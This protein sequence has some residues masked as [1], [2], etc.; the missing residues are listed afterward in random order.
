MRKMRRMYAFV[1]AL[2]LMLALGACE[3][4]TE[5]PE[6][7]A[8]VGDLQDD[9]TALQEDF[10]ALE[11]RVADLEGTVADG[12]T[13]GVEA[14]NPVVDERLFA[15][16]ETFVGQQVTVS[17]EVD[18]VIDTHSFTLDGPQSPLLV[19]NATGS[20]D[21][22]LVEDGAVVSVTGTVHESFSVTDVENEFGLELDDGLYTNFEGQNYV[23]ADSVG[24]PATADS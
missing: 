13:D 8:S 7:G 14:A 15:E 6:E 9:F 11:D 16:P 4:G 24:E 23:A 2:M 12:M 20:G 1:A 21:S 3:S 19:V 18:S 10:G 17:A 22:E 5:G